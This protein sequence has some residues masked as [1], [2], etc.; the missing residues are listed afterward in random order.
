MSADPDFVSPASLRVNDVVA[1]CDGRIALIR[2]ALQWDMVHVGWLFDPTGI[3]TGNEVVPRS[4]L[5]GI[6]AVRSRS[7]H[8]ALLG[9]F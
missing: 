8:L 1:F 7:A 5:V 4:D 6:T 9:D 3:C 2:D